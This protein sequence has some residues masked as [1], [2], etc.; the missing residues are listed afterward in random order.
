MKNSLKMKMSL[1]II[2]VAI[3]VG[4]Q[5]HNSKD[6]ISDAILTAKAKAIT[7]SL[8]SAS[9]TSN[10]ELKIRKSDSSGVIINKVKLYRDDYG[11][12]HITISFKN[13]SGKDI[14]AIKFGVALYNNFD[15]PVP[16]DLDNVFYGIVQEK[17]KNNGTATY[18]WNNYH[19]T[20]TKGNGFVA[21]V[22]FVDGSKWENK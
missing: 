18:S 19:E 4:C 7:D 6:I 14:D 12:G 13:A 5:S 11:G 1:F 15:E 17:I 22:H 21:A 10:Y 20:S 9:M 8:I 16:S 3:T 2:I